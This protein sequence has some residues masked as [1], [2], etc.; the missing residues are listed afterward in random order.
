MKKYRS[1]V[2]PGKPYP[3][4]ATYDGNGVNFAIFSENATSLKLCL[5]H[6]A[7]DE[8]E[9][10][11]VDF[12]EVTDYVWHLY[13][14]GIKPGQLYG[15]RVYGR[16]QPKTG[17]RFNSQKLLIDPYAKAI[18]GRIDIHESM[19]DYRLNPEAKKPTPK[20]NI[21]DSA[22]KMNKCVVIDTS[23]DWEGVQK[24]KIAMHNSIIYELHVKGFTAQH[25]DIPEEERGSYKGLANP[26]IINYFKELGIT[27]IELM[28][29]HHFAHNK[30][31]LD[32]GLNNYWGYN[33][34]GYFAPHAEYSAS[35]SQG[36]Q[37]IEFKEMVKAYHKAGIEIILDVVYNHTAEG[38]HLGPTLAFRGI[39]NEN[40]YRL[41]PENKYYY[42]DYTGTGNTLNMLNART[43]QLVM[44]SLRYW[45]ND[46][47]VDGFR[48]DLAST[49]ARGLYEVGKLST[50]L[51]T[52]HQDPTIS[53]LKL[54][55]EPWDLGEGGYQVGNFP[56][57]WAEWN[58]KYRDCVRKFWRG[59]ESQVSELAFRLSGSSDLYEDNGKMPSSSIN[60]VTAHDGFTL[61]DL[62]SYNNKHNDANLE[63]SMDGESHSLSWNSGVEGPTD[64]EEIIQL[65]ERRKRSFLGTLLLSQGVPM[66]SHGDE[67]GRTQYGNNN[68]YCHDNQLTWMNWDWDE[69]QQKLFE[70]TKKIIH[71]RNNHPVTHRRRYFKNRRIQG[72]GIRDIRWINTDGIDMSQEEWD[73]SFIRGMG[74]LLNGEL[75]KEIDE[76]GKVLGEDILLILVN[77]F[78]EPI[79]FTLPHEGLNTDWEVLVD[80]YL[81]LKDLPPKQVSNVFEIGGRSLVLLKNIK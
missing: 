58:G 75:M 31:L 72:E 59:D 2:L 33:T 19:F 61:H 5:F 55:A 41:E 71:I 18:C 9:Y 48:F 11:Q 46:M 17:M 62:V 47:Q 26:K 21:D 68:V 23:F 66:I 29:I 40:Y 43:L 45:A 76:N 63:D 42:T 56:V 38:N 25:P 6:S 1:Q 10:A 60:F 14:P 54:I 44:D 4:G 78:W 52:I 79:S 13:L 35:D 57:L 24:P 22:F 64:D 49:L 37:V 70:F 50:F 69:N 77:S 20:K 28:P 73:T 74:M 15:Y 7:R 39:D 27:A 80:T 36:D 51:D 34:I 53:Q 67:Y 16:Y 81:P 65:R 12:D 8:H 3:L 30:F 32:K